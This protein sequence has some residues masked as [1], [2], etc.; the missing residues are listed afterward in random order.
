MVA[1]PLTATIRLVRRERYPG[2]VDGR[3]KVAPQQDKPK[4][5]YAT[6]TQLTSTCYS[7]KS[8]L[9]WYPYASV[10]YYAVYYAAPFP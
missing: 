7:K 8:F 9:T 6:L 4:L 2:R 3:K 10:H 5:G 1:M